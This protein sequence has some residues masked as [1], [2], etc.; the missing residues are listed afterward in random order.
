MKQII[1]QPGAKKAAK[2]PDLAK[3]KLPPDKKALD[4]EK[5]R[6][7][8][9]YFLGSVAYGNLEDA[10]RL[11]ENGADIEARDSHG[12][13]ALI[14]AAQNNY[15]EICSFLIEKGADINAS[16][17]DGFNVLRHAQGN[18]M[19]RIAVMIGVV[20]LIG[21]KHEGFLSG[22]RECIK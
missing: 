16:D 3:Q 20:S 14:Y 4:E 21:E 1:R 7:I 6:E 19:K 15:P 22:F 2:Q 11:L 17:Y 5:Q 9:D 10:K 8:N 18:S 12:W 13:T